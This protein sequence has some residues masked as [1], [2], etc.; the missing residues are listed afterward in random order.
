MVVAWLIG[1]PIEFALIFIPYFVTKG[2]YEIQWHSNSVKQCFVISTLVF[3]LA[4]TVTLDKGFS[5]MFSALVGLIIAYLSYR[6][7]II[8]F[9]L[10]DYEFIEPRYN[11]LVE[12]YN[13]NENKQIDID[14][15]TFEEFSKVCK[16]NK[17]PRSKVSEL[18]DL[19]SMPLDSYCDK[20]NMEYQSANNK[21]CKYRKKLNM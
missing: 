12:Y 7:G 13:N 9:K 10:E 15:C 5:L 3:A 6:A 4:I 14:N 8:K 17:I 1:K 21:R 2:W 19:F 16:K 18:Y 20:Y 11:Q